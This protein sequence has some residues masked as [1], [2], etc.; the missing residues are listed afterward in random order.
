MAQALKHLLR[1]RGDGFKGQALEVFVL[2][3]MQCLHARIMPAAA[4]HCH[5]EMR[6]QRTA[7]T[8]LGF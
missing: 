5:W 6:C 8:G 1:E 7:F 4:T 2:E 3:I